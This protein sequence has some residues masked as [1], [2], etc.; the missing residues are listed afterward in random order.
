M[1]GETLWEGES[2]DLTS[3]A[4]GGKV[5]KKRYRITAEYIYE[6]SGLLGSK[7][8][9]IPLW[10]VRDIDVVQSMIQKARNVGNVKVRVEPNE[11]T[12]KTAIVLE[13]IQSAKEVRDLIN[14]HARV[15][16]DA[17]LRQ[18]QNVTYTGAIPVAGVTQAPQ[19]GGSSE[20]PIEKLTKLGA[21]LQSG[22][23][24]QE[25]FDAQKAKLL[26]L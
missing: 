9:Q 5:V 13:N 25:E 11:Y 22:L 23:I 15:A 2:N 1:A 10:A 12:G 18:Q 19:P 20:D 17:R 3:A 4:T 21:L 8:E 7:E 16:R 24:T 26:G 14:D 6:S